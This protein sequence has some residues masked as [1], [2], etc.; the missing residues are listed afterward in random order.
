MNKFKITVIME[1]KVTYALY[2]M[3]YMYIL[4]NSTY[5]IIFKIR[6]PN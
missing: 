6:E 1:N 3:I 5:L 2:N 4:K